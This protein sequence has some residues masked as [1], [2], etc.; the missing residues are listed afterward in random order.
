MADIIVMP[1]KLQIKIRLKVRPG[2][3]G[4]A[5]VNF[6]LIRIQKRRLTIPFQTRPVQA[7]YHFIKRVRRNQIVMIHKRNVTPVC[8]CKAAVGIFGNPAVFRKPFVADPAI[9]LFI[10]FHR[11]FDAFRTAA[12]RKAEFPVRICLL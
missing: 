10:P 8:H 11:L 4:S 6:I 2:M 5:A 3:H 7:A 9:P 12:V 1:Q